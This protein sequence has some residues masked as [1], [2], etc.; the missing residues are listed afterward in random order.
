MGKSTAL[1]F[2]TRRAEGRRARNGVICCKAARLRRWPAP[3]G[4]AQWQQTARVQGGLFGRCSQFR[5]SPREGDEDLRERPGLYTRWRLQHANPHKP[6]GPPVARSPPNGVA[7]THDLLIVLVLI[8]TGQRLKG[9]G[10]LGLLATCLK[11]RGA[12]GRCSNASDPDAGKGGRF[13]L[14]W[15]TSRGLAP[16]RRGSIFRTKS[17]SCAECFQSSRTERRINQVWVA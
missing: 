7:V 10:H 6:A 5:S 13:R 8:G 16:R 15:R 1:C 4:Q 2:N 14:V 11:L 17:I 9:R 3:A 12:H